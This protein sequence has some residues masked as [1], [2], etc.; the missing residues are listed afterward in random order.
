MANDQ[1]FA[2]EE[3]NANRIKPHCAATEGLNDRRTKQAMQRRSREPWH[4]QL[5]Y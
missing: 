5:I 3:R 2:F 4:E 1:G